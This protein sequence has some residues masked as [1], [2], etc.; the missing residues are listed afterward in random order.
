MRIWREHRIEDMLDA[1]VARDNGQPLQQRHALDG[2]RRQSKCVRKLPMLVA[3]HLERHLQ[4]LHHLLLIRRVLGTQPEHFGVQAGKVLVMIP[5]AARFRRAAASAGDGV[6]PGWQLPIRPAGHRIAIDDDSRRVDLRD[7]D[8]AIRRR[9][10][11]DIGQRHAVEMFR[12]P[13]VRRPRQIG[14]QLVQIRL[15]YGSEQRQREKRA[16]LHRRSY[17]ADRQVSCSVE[18]ALRSS[19]RPPRDWCRRAC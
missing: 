2:E 12:A 9:R 15:R 17:T 1:V 13:I 8:H 16:A 18:L 5:E 10:Q 14:R 3:Q 6:P 7:V 4:P 11:A 19:E